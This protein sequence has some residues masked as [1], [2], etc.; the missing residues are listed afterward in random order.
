MVGLDMVR[1]VKDR[2]LARVGEGRVR[3]CA[4]GRRSTNRGDEF[5]VR[6]CVE[7][8]VGPTTG[9]ELFA[10]LR[11]ERRPVRFSSSSSASSLKVGPL[12]TSIPLN[13][14]WL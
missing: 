12:R 14:A 8:K 1:R 4:S 3:D 13:S 6:D 10:V 2:I 11:R 5:V 9:E 7:G